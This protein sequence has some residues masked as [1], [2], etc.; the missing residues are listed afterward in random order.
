M[1]VFRMKPILPRLLFSR[2]AAPVLGL[3]FSL[4]PVSAQEFS[5]PGFVD[6]RLYSGNGMISIAF[7][8]EGNLLVAEKRGRVLLLK[9][10]SGVTAPS[11]AYQYYE[12]T[13]TSLPD[14]STLTPVATGTVS[15]ITLEPRLRNDYFAL[16]FTGGIELPADGEYTFYTRS[17]D[18]SRIYLNGN[19]VVD[20]DGT[21]GATEKAGAVTL[22]AGTHELR[23]EYF[24]NAGGE[25]LEVSYSGPGIPKQLIGE[26]SGPY[27]APTVFSDIVSQVNTDA[28]RGLMGLALDPDYQ[29]NRYIYL[30]FSAATDQKIIRQTAN[31][32]FTGVEPG[33]DLVL[34]SGLPNTSG[35][36]KAGDI[37]FRPGEPYNLYVMLGDDGQRYIVGNLDNYNGKLLRIDSSTGLGLADN[38][39]YDGNPGSVRSR[40]WSH[41]YRNPYRFAFD[42]ADASPDAL[43]ISENGDGTD[44]IARI[45][46]GADGGWDNQFLTSSPDGKRK[47]LHTTQPSLTGIVFVRGGPFAPDGPVIYNARYGGNDRKEIRRWRVTGDQLDALEPIAG[48][49]GEP[50]FKGYSYNIASL[51]H[52]P[53]GSLYYTDSNQGSSTGSGYR[54]GRIRYI[55]G[56]AP[57]AAFSADPD[58]ASGIAPLAVQ[59]ADAST[60]TDAPIVGWAWDFGDGETSTAPSPQHTYN[61]PG[62]HTVRLT[63]TDTAGLT[64]SAVSEVTVY[65]PASL[66]LNGMILDARQQGTAGPFGVAT[67]LR[68]YQ[69]DGITPLPFDGGLGDHGNIL[70]IAA[71]GV[72]GASVDVFLTGP[73][74]V[75]SAGESPDDGVSPAFAGFSLPF[76][77]GEHTVEILFHLAPTLI[78]GRATDTLGNAAPLDIGISR[79]SAQTPYP[80]AGGRDFLPASG[81][82]PSGVFHRVVADDLGYFHFPVADGDGGETFTLD[83]AADT[84]SSTHGKVKVDP[85]VAEGEGIE[86]NLLIGLYQAGTG[87]DDLSSIA[88]TPGV[89]FDSQIQPILSAQCMACH[90]DIATNSGGLDLQPGAGYEELVNVF[91]VGAPG[92]K[93]VEPGRPD[94]SFLMEKINSSVPQ[95][96]TRMR[97]GDPMAPELQALVRDWISQLA[98][99]H[100]Y[101]TWRQGVFGEH[102]GDPATGP[103]EDFDGDGV[104]N[105]IAYALGTSPLVPTPP[106]ALPSHEFTG[107]DGKNHLTLRVVRDPSAAGIVCT[108][109]ASG[110]LSPESWSPIETVVITDEPSLLLVRS[111]LPIGEEPRRFMRL[112]VDL[113]PQP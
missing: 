71:G 42:P 86:R 92:V 33:S 26:N 13:W 113:D 88:E 85:T 62:V 44:R 34:L 8:H 63:V 70:P 31:S 1:H 101:E 83:T 9:Q 96:G 32:T 4:Q 93:L 97:P 106:S 60:F 29:N 108:I 58:P 46:K 90:N 24:E 102:A 22:N 21:H 41:R 77:S 89:D 56:D 27:L 74:V 75:V 3:A 95:T 2:A 81:R 65:H 40:I 18:G 107:I 38:P 17:D 30:L 28:E 109:E 12:G 53:D 84:L 43:Y 55:G 112:R 59:F 5:V 15:S 80:V 69:S 48:D 35:V 14:F 19:L 45:A 66:T 6:E 98:Q 105:L 68:L 11:F 67:D 25:A 110:D 73:G 99:P 52:G 54:L 23:V 47:I 39:H 103:H 79:G 104:S 64:H 82:P 37:G 10:N 61:A 49:E 16:T 72:I 76:S 100:P 91:S 94:R 111:L 51:T 50:F 20:H 57:V 7:D 87:T 78:R 36:H